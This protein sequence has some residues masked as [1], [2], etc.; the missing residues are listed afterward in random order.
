MKAIL[1]HHIQRLRRD[2]AATVNGLNNCHVRNLQS[3]MLHDEP[4]NRMRLFY[5]NT[6]HPLYNN[7]AGKSFSLAIHSHHCDVTLINLFG[8]A[9]NRRHALIPNPNGHFRKYK[10]VSAVTGGRAALVPADEFFDAPL[11][12]SEQ[13]SAGPVMLRA[14]E[15]HTIHVP[16]AQEAAWMVLEGG[17]DAAYSSVC[18]TNNEVFNPAELYEKMNRQAVINALE[19]IVA[20]M[21][22]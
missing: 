14:Y 22:D 6:G 12:E 11:L 21:K 19:N 15:L 8:N 5:A 3:I 7:V 16:V 20:C 4:G 9:T 1:W 18:Y 13:L 2:A 17:E 10:Y